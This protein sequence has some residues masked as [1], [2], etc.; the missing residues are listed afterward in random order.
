MKWT[1][2]SLAGLEAFDAVDRHGSFTRAAKALHVTQS[3]ELTRVSDSNG[4]G[5]L[6]EDEMTSFIQS[7]PARGQRGGQRGGEGGAGRRPGQAPGARG[8]MP[9]AQQ[10]VHCRNIAQQSWPLPDHR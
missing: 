3:C 4:D 8:S 9:V 10:R 5:F 6:T 7:R 1:L 2:P